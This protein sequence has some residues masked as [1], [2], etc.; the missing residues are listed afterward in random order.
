MIKDLISLDRELKDDVVRELFPAFEAKY[1]LDIP[2]SRHL[3]EDIRFWKWGLNGKYS[4]K[5]GYLFQLG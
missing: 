2:L 5:S 4:V 1:I 3:S